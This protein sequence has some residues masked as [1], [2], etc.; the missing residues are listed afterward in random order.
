MHA[1]NYTLKENVDNDVL[2]NVYIINL[3]NRLFYLL[4][5]YLWKVMKK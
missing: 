4:G 1:F 3:I 2:E 5:I